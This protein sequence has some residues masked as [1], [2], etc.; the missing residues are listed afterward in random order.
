MAIEISVFPFF[1]QGIQFVVD[2]SGGF[3]GVA[4]E[5]LE[6]IADDYPNIPVLLYSVRSPDSCLDSRN[7]KLTISRRLH[8]AI[9]FAKQSAL[10]KLIVPVGLPSLSTSKHAIILRGLS[11]SNCS[12]CTLKINGISVK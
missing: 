11:L 1:W 10:C 2:D 7:R 9:S 4:G 6:I 3:S 5:V 8:D 12:V